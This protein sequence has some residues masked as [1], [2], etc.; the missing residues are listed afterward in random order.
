MLLGLFLFLIF[1]LVIQFTVEFKLVTHG[2][3]V[4]PRLKFGIGR[5]LLSIPQKGLAKM[6][7]GI[8]KR[9]FGS[10]EAMVKGSKLGLRLADNF[11]QKIDLL[12]LKVLIGVGDPFL[13]AVGVGGVWALMGPFLTGL[14]TK[15]RLNTIPEILVQPNFN[16]SSVQV[17]LH[18]IFHFRLGQIIINELKRME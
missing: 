12:S 8:R 17:N 13:T 1:F 3:D 18:C 11:L 14:G 10:V 15:N 16:E 6:S 5:F 4:T 9:N 2:L 7:Q